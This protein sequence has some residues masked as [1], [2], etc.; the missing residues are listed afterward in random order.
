MPGRLSTTGVAVKLVPTTR[1]LVGLLLRLTLVAAPA[2]ATDTR[3]SGDTTVTRCAWTRG[4]GDNATAFGSI[5]SVVERMR[6][7]IRVVSLQRRTD[8]GWVQVSTRRS[9]LWIRGGGQTRTASIECADAGPGRYRSRSTAQW[10]R[11]VDGTV[12]TDRLVS[13]PVRRLRLCD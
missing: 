5:A 7:R 6:V 9:R 8:H 2:S 11:G 3:C 12:H 13:A 4:E 10:K 1:A